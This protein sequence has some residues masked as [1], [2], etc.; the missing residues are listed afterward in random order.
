M[1]VEAGVQRVKEGGLVLPPGHGDQKGPP[2]PRVSPKRASELQAVHDGHGEIAQDGVGADAREQAETVAPVFGDC[3]TRAEHLEQPAKE[4]ARLDV[5]LDD[6]D[7]AATQRRRTPVLRV[8][9]GGS[10][11]W[12]G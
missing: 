12:R 2:V 3:H 11:A 5:V 4:I 6:E 7:R 10:P 8:R 1:G 9:P